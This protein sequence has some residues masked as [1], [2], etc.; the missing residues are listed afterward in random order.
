M[1]YW[2]KLE[3]L[4]IRRKDGGIL[5]CMACTV[6]Q[7]KKIQEMGG[8]LALKVSFKKHFAIHITVAETG[9][10]TFLHLFELRCVCIKCCAAGLFGDCMRYLTITK[11]LV[12]F[13]CKQFRSSI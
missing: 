6:R 11:K 7:D 13:I 8:A 5:C 2:Q 9:E 10:K 3:G 1:A 12:L 4:Q